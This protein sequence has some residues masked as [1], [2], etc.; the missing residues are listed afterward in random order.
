MTP[1]YIKYI[2]IYHISYIIAVMRLWGVRIHQL[3]KCRNQICQLF[4]EVIGEEWFATQAEGKSHCGHTSCYRGKNP[5]YG[6]HCINIRN[7]KFKTM[8]QFCFHELTRF[9]WGLTHDGQ[10]EVSD[11][12]I[13][14]DRPNCL[15]QLR[16]RCG[17]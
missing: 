9:S 12:P 4:V 16:C 2:Y 5:D 10:L 6:H 14:Y 15:K 1:Y 8:N 3:Q 17:I 13:K 11:P 7:S